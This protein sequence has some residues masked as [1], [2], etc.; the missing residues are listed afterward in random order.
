MLEQLENTTPPERPSNDVPIQPRSMNRI[1]TDDGVVNRDQTATPFDQQETP[2]TEAEAPP[3]DPTEAALQALLD[4]HEATSSSDEAAATAE[5]Q[6]SETSDEPNFDAPEMKAFADQFKQYTGIDLKKAFDTY[7]QMAQ[8]LETIR[9]QQQEV[10]FQQAVTNLKSEWGVNDAEFNSRIQAVLEYSNKLPEDLRQQFD[11][12]NG[13]KMLWKQ[14]SK[15]GGV[16]P[17]TKTVPVQSGGG[18][19][20]YRKSEL[21][22]IM[23]TNPGLYN[24][25]QAEIQ[26]AFESGR[27]IDD[28]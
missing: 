6:T 21:H 8:Q 2:A 9:Q 5:T 4:E 17:T 27:V 7:N 10:E 15:G 12:P 19:K 16:Q 1:L 18:E 23:A 25:M 20:T 28:L 22:Q 13:I 24:K 11:S 14:I 26:A 3:V